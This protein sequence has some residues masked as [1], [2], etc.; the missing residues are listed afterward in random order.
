MI[1]FTA[2][3]ITDTLFF[4][5]GVSL[6]IRFI[7]GDKRVGIAPRVIDNKY[8]IDYSDP[9]LHNLLNPTSRKI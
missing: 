9:I 1:Y 4:L 2:N 3:Q 6:Q 5:K 7:R 8:Y